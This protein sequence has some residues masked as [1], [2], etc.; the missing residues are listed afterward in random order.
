MTEMRKLTLTVT[1]EQ[2]GSRVKTLL[3]R[4]FHM[5]D[6]LIAR[7]KLRETGLLLN[8]RRVY[9]NAVVQTG[10]VLTAE[11]GDDA[12]GWEFPPIRA[13]LDIVFEDADL[14]IL[15][16]AAGMAVHGKTERTG[17][18]TVA[19]AL[20]YRFGPGYRFHPVNRL[21]KNTSGLVLC[22]KS[23]FAA[24]ALSGCAEKEYL[25]LAQG[26]LPA[27][28]GRIDAPIARRSDSIIGR[29]VSPDGKP[30]VTLYRVLASDGRLSLVAC[31]LLTGRTHQI[32]VHLSWLGNPL[33]GDTLYGGSD[34]EIARHA[35]HCASM[36]FSQP[37]TGQTVLVHSSMPQDMLLCC[38]HHFGSID[39]LLDQ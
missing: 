20:A 28:E 35:L 4:D 18:A 13:P 10:D 36:R 7:V 30:S 39:Q 38:E 34:R 21:D 14:L 16:K 29:C 32:R 23:A 37:V 15:N 22:A 24:A 26:T 6:S 12:T 31:R 8:G 2:A 25:A 27:E 11:V 33:A 3:L 5:A 17:E 1:R 19:N 9:T